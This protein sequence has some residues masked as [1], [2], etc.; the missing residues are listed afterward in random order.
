MINFM[1]NFCD[2][3]KTLASQEHGKTYAVTWVNSATA[4]PA[5]LEFHGMSPAKVWINTRNVP[6]STGSRNEVP[7]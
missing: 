5:A 3:R 6:I 4:Q 7:I 1:K 2:L